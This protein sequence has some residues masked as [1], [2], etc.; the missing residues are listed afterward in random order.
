MTRFPMA[1]PWHWV[2]H[3]VLVLLL[4]YISYQQLGKFIK[5]RN[6]SKHASSLVQH[7][8]HIIHQKGEACN[9]CVVSFKWV[10]HALLMHLGDS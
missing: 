6:W 4:A 8:Q 10:V 9:P 5:R 1:V 2:E 7:A 3:A